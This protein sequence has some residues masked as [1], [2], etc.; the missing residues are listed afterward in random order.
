MNKQEL[1]WAAGFFDGEG[2]AYLV[3]TRQQNS[4][5]MAVNI[6]Q[7]DPRPLQRFVDALG[8]GKVGGPYKTTGGANK[9]R[10]QIQF[11]GKDHVHQF[12]WMLWPYLS[13]PKRE[14]ID[15]VWSKY[16]YIRN[17]RKWTS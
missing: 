17:G 15:R 5:T 8:F 12:I 13:E 9:D 3:K 10:W 14:Q 6:G 2:S 16:D 11:S 7:T 1:A 4:P